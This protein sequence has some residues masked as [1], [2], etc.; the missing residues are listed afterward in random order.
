M[1][2]ASPGEYWC[3]EY[4][5]YLA[6]Q[7]L[8]GQS[9]LGEGGGWASGA[10]VIILPTAIITSQKGGVTDQLLVTVPTMREAA[11]PSFLY[12]ENNLINLPLTSP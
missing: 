6:E 12:D 7:T 4:D 8:A 1:E 3:S 11:G 9:G 5:D 10:L 2:P